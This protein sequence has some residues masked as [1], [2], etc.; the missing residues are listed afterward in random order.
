MITDLLRT[1][2]FLYKNTGNHHNFENFIFFEVRQELCMAGLGLFK[3]DLA[4]KK[5]AFS[6]GK[7]LIKLGIINRHKKIKL[8]HT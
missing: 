3:I 2:K 1:Y 5:E 4:H 6:R 7:I 8:I